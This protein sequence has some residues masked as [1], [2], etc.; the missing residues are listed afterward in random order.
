MQCPKCQ[1]ENR[2]EAKFCLKC[3]NPLELR[4]GNPLELRCG[5]P[6]ELRCPNYQT[7]LPVGAIFCDGYGILS[8]K[9]KRIIGEGVVAVFALFSSILHL[10]N[11]S[12]KTRDTA[13]SVRFKKA[14]IFQTDKL[15][16]T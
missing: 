2:E 3:G 12:R 14:E 10:P 11:G 1:S 8:D 5:N 16:L 15:F 6:L 7:T 4:C 13:I 9:D